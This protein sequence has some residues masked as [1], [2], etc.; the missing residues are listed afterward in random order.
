[1]CYTGSSVCV[2]VTGSCT[3]R[4]ENKTMYCIVSVFG[5]AFWLAG[6]CAR[7]PMR[8]F[9]TFCFDCF[10]SRGC[11]RVVIPMDCLRGFL[12]SI[13][14]YFWQEQFEF[15]IVVSLFD[16]IYGMYFIVC[17]VGIHQRLHTRCTLCCM[18]TLSGHQSFK[19]TL[20]PQSNGPLYSNAVIGTLAVDGWAR[21]SK[22]GP[23]QLRPVPSSL[24]QM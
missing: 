23:G 2:C 24:Y 21:Y 22:E 15:G 4:W 17:T 14:V 16:C 13:L 7:Y 8:L 20:K 9:Y 5:L 11:G 10:E 6:V 1:M 18:F 19:G 3:V 12:C